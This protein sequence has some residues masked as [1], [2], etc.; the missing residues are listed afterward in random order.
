MP[1]DLSTPVAVI[2]VIT[3]SMGFYLLAGRLG[4]SSQGSGDKYAPFTGGE[5]IPPS[6]GKYHSELFVYAALFMVFEV[7]AL[8]LAGA[9]HS[10]TALLPLIFTATGGVAIFAA[11]VWFVQT[12]GQPF[13]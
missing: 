5:R 8:L 7:F 6:R 1:V 13:A 11:V 9:I 2:V 10:S 12:G 3:A 4:R